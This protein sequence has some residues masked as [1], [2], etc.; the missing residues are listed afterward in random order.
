LRETVKYRNFSIQWHFNTCMGEIESDCIATSS[1]SIVKIL[2]E[3]GEPLKLSLLLLLSSSSSSVTVRCIPW[4]PIQS[5]IRSSLW[6]LHANFLFP[7]S[8]DPLIHMGSSFTWSPS[9]SRSVH[10]SCYYLFWQSFFIY[11]VTC[12][13]HH[14]VSALYHL[15]CYYSPEMEWSELREDPRSRREMRAIATVCCSKA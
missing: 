9:F 8:S 14:N 1:G 6:P 15:V 13:F 4:L 10:S 5:S 7:L 3:Y 12:P 2:G 11:L